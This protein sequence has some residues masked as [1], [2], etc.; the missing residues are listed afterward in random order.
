M[1]LQKGIHFD[2]ALV[3]YNTRE[4]SNKEEQH[5]KEL[6]KKYNLKC[7]TKKAPNFES[8][9]EKSA[10]EFRYEFFEQ[11]MQEHGHDVL[12]TAHQLNDQL[13]W[14]LMRLSKG[15]GFSELIGLEEVVQ[16]D[17]YQLVRPLLNYTKDELLEYLN[18]HDYPYF[19]DISNDSNKFERNRFRKEFSNQLMEQF[20]SGIKRSFAYMHKDKT[21]L[22]DNFSLVKKEKQLRVLKL[23]N[24]NAKAKAVDITLKEFGYLL[25]ASQRD[26]VTNS[27]SLVIGG[28]WA[29]ETQDSLVY[30]APFETQDMPKEFKELCRVNGVPNKIR[31][32]LYAKKIDI[33]VAKYSHISGTVL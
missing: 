22:N 29:I 18:Q 7:F 24:L 31:P 32:Y 33:T 11:T 2:I 28:L 17:G 5:A 10:R 8:N 23:H 3:N 21:L 30:I 15:A 19:E 16:K 1:L 12:L 26:E 20:T 6:A 14:F 13:E 9:F 4:E 27:N 25:S